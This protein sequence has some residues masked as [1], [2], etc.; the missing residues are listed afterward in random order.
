MSNTR[1]VNRPKTNHGATIES[2]MIGKLGGKRE[3]GKWLDALRKTT[4]DKK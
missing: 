2:V 3:Y 4:R 1:I